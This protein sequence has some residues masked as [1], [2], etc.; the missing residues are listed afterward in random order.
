MSSPTPRQATR[1]ALLL[2]GILLIAANLRAPF[3]GLPPLLGLIRDDIAL[4]TLAAS[5]LTTLPLLAFAIIS[6][7]SAT[8]AHRFGLQRA[9]FGALLTI[10][11]GILLR[12]AGGV[13][14]LYLGTSL[15]GMGIAVGNVLLP[16]LIKR[17]F[18]HHIAAVTGAYALAMGAAA[19]LFS[20]IAVPLADALGW[21]GALTSFLVLPV[22]ALAVWFTQLRSRPG[23][24]AST[25]VPPPDS[26]IRHSWLAWQITLF[27]GL[28]STI[29]Y[30]GIGWLPAILTD[31][32]MSAEQAGSLHGVLQFA[33]AIPGLLSGL[34]LR[35]LDDQRLAAA[36]I[37]GLTATAL[38]G[39]MIA[40]GLALLWSVLFGL[41]TG[42]GIILGLTFI[43]L[44]TRNAQQA[45]ALS[46]MSQSM[47][48]LLAAI[49]PVAAGLLHDQ[50]GNWQVPLG[51]CFVFALIVAL[52]GV[53]AGRNRYIG[54]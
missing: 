22:A 1:Q 11:L 50:V 23:P 53:L 3:T 6:P 33:T 2:V 35:R 43:G 52:M 29:Y 34:I 44:R 12:S 31:A 41:G 16:G 39:L 17:D 30:I 7:F 45:A 49:G 54:D 27:F 40:P 32:G 20:G 19:A 14:G 36:V 25:Q 38:L 18:P 15:I 48:Y 21:R 51:V 42:A 46:G 8:L 13:A 5:A 37:A 26:K 24:A 28:N 47:G 10:A 9:L 4:N